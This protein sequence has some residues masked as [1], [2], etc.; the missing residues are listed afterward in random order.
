MKIENEYGRQR[1]SSKKYSPRFIDLDLL[2]FDDL[3]VKKNNIILPHP[4]IHIR[5]FVLAPLCEIAPDYIH[6][7][8]KLAIKEIYSKS[9]DLLKVRKLNK[10]DYNN[11]FPIYCS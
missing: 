6:P 3:I 9:K 1:D 7:Y 8:F 10:L 4:K 5:N 2:F 11:C